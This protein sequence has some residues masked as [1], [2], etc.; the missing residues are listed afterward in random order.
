M[1]AS[2]PKTE[3]AFIELFEAINRSLRPAVVVMQES[4]P[5]PDWAAP[6]GEVLATF[7]SRLGAVGLVSD[8]ETLGRYPM[9]ARSAGAAH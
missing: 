8:L 2:S 5:H 9:V 6:C 7:F 1:T 4:G 3:D